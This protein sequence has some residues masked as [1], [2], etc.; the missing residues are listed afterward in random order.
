MISYPNFKRASWKPIRLVGRPSLSFAGGRKSR[1]GHHVE[2]GGLGKGQ[3]H[4]CHD[5]RFLFLPGSKGIMPFRKIVPTTIFV[6]CPRV[7]CNL[8]VAER[9][10][11]CRRYSRICFQRRLTRSRIWTDRDG[12]IL[13][14][15]NRKISF[16]NHTAKYKVQIGICGWDTI[17]EPRQWFLSCSKHTILLKIIQKTRSFTIYSVAKCVKNSRNWLGL[18]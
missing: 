10:S 8:L 3:G 11:R 5:A 7:R 15:L 14:I 4:F 17:P 16:P 6:K 18:S 12:G 1:K 9:Y 2:D 13:V